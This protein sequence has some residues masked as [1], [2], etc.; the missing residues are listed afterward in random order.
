MNYREPFAWL[1]I[2]GLIFFIL[3][4]RSE[5][6]RQ[7]LERSADNKL[8]QQRIEELQGRGE[9]AARRA[10]SLQANFVRRH[11]SDSLVLSGFKM[12]NSAMSKKLAEQRPTLQP[13]IDSL[14]PV[15]DY[16][17]LADSLLAAKDIIITHL[18]LSHEA[19]VVDLE[20]IIKARED[21]ILVEATKGH[22]WETVAIETE[23]EAN[24][25][26]RRKGFWRTSAAILAGGVL[27]LTISK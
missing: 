15:R 13:F 25:Q 19:E 22:L 5:G 9:T 2:V 17:M 12:R 11:T 23:K 26:R 1:I 10:D 20:A 21:Q 3:W 24:Q 7:Q 27:F 4:Q 18:T 16:V 6:K 8:H 14:Q